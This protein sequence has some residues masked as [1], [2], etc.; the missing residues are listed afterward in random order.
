[1]N[2]K[3]STYA[4]VITILILTTVSAL[5]L[6][7]CISFVLERNTAYYK[8]KREVN[9]I[10]DRISNTLAV[11]LWVFDDKSVEKMIMLEMTNPDVIAI[12]VYNAGIPYKGKVKSSS[13]QI[14]DYDP[15]KKY[16]QLKHAFFRKKENIIKGEEVVGTV[17]LYFTDNFL[18]QYLKKHL[19]LSFAK[20]LILSLIILVS[21]FVCL[22]K[23]IFTSLNKI[24][25]KVH[26]LS[27]GEGDLT[28][29]FCI[30]AY[31]EMGTLCGSFNKFL[32]KQREMIGNILAHSKETTSIA[33]ELNFMSEE[34]SGTINNITVSLEDNI[35]NNRDFFSMITTTKKEIELLVRHIHT[36]LE[37]NTQTV[38]GFS[39]ILEMTEVGKVSANTAGSK[40]EL[41]KE[42]AADTRRNVQELKTKTEQIHQIVEVINKILKQTNMLALNAAIEASRAGEAGKGFAVVANEVKNLAARTTEA[43]N[44]IKSVINEIIESTD[45]VVFGISNNV[46]AINDGGEIIKKALSE[47]ES[48][49]K[50]IE[51]ITGYFQKVQTASNEQL[52]ISS[53]VHEKIVEVDKYSNQSTETFKQLSANI[54]YINSISE[55]ITGTS[56]TLANASSKLLNLVQK[57]KI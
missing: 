30:N 15:T 53:N 17:E 7:D 43:T 37:G 45:N 38:T 25:L 35:Q 14:T 55:K 9:Q 12:V 57:F 19:L 10:T 6:F 8:I 36:I 56:S 1:M 54:D 42:N 31:D 21:A 2:I 46:E 29:S 44:E 22:K 51:V 32:G 27:E 39:Q 33:K 5:V 18:R 20:S 16:D 47:M 50:E 4:K 34:L 24:V 23:F 49:G 11:P 41:I 52:Y 28:R 48:I 26:E 40:L 3:N 13:Y